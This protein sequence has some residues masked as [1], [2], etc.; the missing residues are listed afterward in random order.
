MRALYIV[1]T[2]VLVLF[3]AFFVI[4][5]YALVRSSRARLEGLVD[6]GLRGARLSGK[7]PRYC[8]FGG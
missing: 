2:A 3:N 1:L 7:Y 6:E 5:E 4:A 8:A